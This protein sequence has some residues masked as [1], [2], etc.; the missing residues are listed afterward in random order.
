MKS[1]RLSKYITF[2]SLGLIVGGSL[3]FSLAMNLLIVPMS[4][5]S[6]GFLGIAQL[7]R[8]V[9]LRLGVQVENIDVAGIAYLLINVPLF[10]ISFR[11]IGKPFFVKTLVTVGCYTLF[12]TIIVSPNQPIITDRLTCCLIGGVIAGIGAGMT[13]LSGG[14]GGGE[15]ILGVYLVKKNPFFSVGKLSILI[16]VFVYG[17]C[18]VFFDIETVVYSL[19]YSGFTNLFIDKMHHQNIMMDILII[20]KKEGLC[21]LILRTTGRGATHWD[22]YG[23]YTDTPTNIL[24]T[25]VSKREYHALRKIIKEFD[26]DAFVVINEDI[27]VMGNFEV[28]T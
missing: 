15:E 23:G 22:G 5:Y 19:I 28:R 1:I 27:E 8:E 16:N 17:C 9:L 13:L 24:L 26:P 21:D 12:L 6:G 7:L 2:K 3:L 20:S 10:L 4:L 25:V 18:L 11:S 14:C